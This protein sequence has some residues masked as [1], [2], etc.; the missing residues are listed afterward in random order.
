MKLKTLLVI[1]GIFVGI[2][3]LSG[4]FS[5]GFVA[6]RTVASIDDIPNIFAEKSVNMTEVHEEFVDI[7]RGDTPQEL[8]E[9]F[10]P[11]WQTWNLVE[12]D[13]VEQP[14]DHEIMMRGAINGMLELVGRPAHVLP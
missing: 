12:A 10:E 6:G 1:G 2:I 3:L 5:A 13:Y 4:I 14:V 9:L 11:F 8:E 7:S